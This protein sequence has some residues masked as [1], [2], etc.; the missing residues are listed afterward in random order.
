MRGDDNYDPTDRNHYVINPASTNRE[1]LL[2]SKTKRPIK[3][4]ANELH[5]KTKNGVP[6]KIELTGVQ[7]LNVVNPITIFSQ[8]AD[9]ALAQKEKMMA[10]ATKVKAKTK[11][12]AS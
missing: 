2:D 6:T 3:T 4:V 9:I 11:S 7:Y 5:Y 10:P 1:L 8:P 12:V